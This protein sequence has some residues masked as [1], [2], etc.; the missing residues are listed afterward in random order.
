LKYAETTCEATQK[1]GFVVYA[2]AEPPLR[3][4]AWLN[5]FPGAENV[6][7]VCEFEECERYRLLKAEGLLNLVGKPLRKDVIQQRTVTSSGGSNESSA[8]AVTESKA[9]TLCKKVDEARAEL[10]R[11]AEKPEYDAK[12][13]AF[14]EL[15]GQRY[16][17]VKEELEECK[18]VIEKY[19]E[20]VR[21]VKKNKGK[22]WDEEDAPKFQRV[23][24]DYKVMK[25]RK[26]WLTE[27]DV[28]AK[29]KKRKRQEERMVEAEKK[30]QKIQADDEAEYAK[31]LAWAKERPGDVEFECVSLTTKLGEKS[32]DWRRAER[33][34]V[35]K[36]EE[37]LECCG[38]VKLMMM[39][40]NVNKKPNHQVIA[41]ARRA[42]TISQWNATF[43]PARMIVQDVADVR[44]DWDEA[45]D[46]MLEFG[47]ESHTLYFSPE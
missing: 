4:T 36:L 31:I 30:K 14:L 35:Q 47:I 41:Q 43:A 12:R 24:D 42:M 7:K 26:Q 23:K 28:E 29:N 1:R 32:V 10:E 17:A 2:Y 38:I 44:I 18:R 45:T 19:E 5:L 22:E 16:Q 9:E 6:K 40:D 20:L 39:V 3:K 25:K 21:E 46:N 13:A 27:W 15:S 34:T 8:K 37:W 33:P 11:L